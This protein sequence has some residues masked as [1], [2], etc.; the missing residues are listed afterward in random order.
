MKSADYISLA[1]AEEEKRAESLPV[2]ASLH[3]NRGAS[4][5]LG[6]RI[7]FNDAWGRAIEGILRPSSITIQI[8]KQLYRDVQVET[9]DGRTL[10]FDPK[11]CRKISSD[12][13]SP[14]EIIKTMVSIGLPISFRNDD[15]TIGGK[16]IRDNTVKAMLRRGWL[17][18][19]GEHHLLPTSEGNEIG[20]LAI[21][22]GTKS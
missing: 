12:Q 4:L 9:D 10:P 22:K 2:N 14:I 17:R 7:T 6:D 8:G 20:S 5:H 16:T 18:H 13:S 1:I 15:W 21:K 19:V 11:G 3:D